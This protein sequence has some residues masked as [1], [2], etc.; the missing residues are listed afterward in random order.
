MKSIVCIKIILNLYNLERAIQKLVSLQRVC[1]KFCV[2]KII[3]VVNFTVTVQKM[4]SVIFYV[5][6]A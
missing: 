5:V 6:P 2:G 3:D 1:F 4:K